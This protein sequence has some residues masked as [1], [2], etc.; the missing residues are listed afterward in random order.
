MKVRWGGKYSRFTLV[1]DAVAIEVL[2]VGSSIEEASE[3]LRPL[4]RFAPQILKRSMQEVSSV[5]R[6]MKSNNAEWMS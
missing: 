5:E 1:L 6:L 3:L 4:W 2:L